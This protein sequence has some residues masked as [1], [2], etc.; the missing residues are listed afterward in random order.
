MS[1]YP[2]A[3]LALDAVSDFQ[4]LSICPLAKLAL[5]AVAA[6]EGGIESGDGVRGHLRD[7]L[8]LVPDESHH[9][10]AN[11]IIFSRNLGHQTHV[12]P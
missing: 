4:T 9:C 2:L 7:R 5:D 8:I 1:I 6:F 3:K 11:P 10:F 12:I